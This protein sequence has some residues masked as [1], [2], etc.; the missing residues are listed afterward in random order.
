MYCMQRLNSLSLYFRPH[1]DLKLICPVLNLTSH[2]F[3]FKILIHVRVYHLIRPVLNSSSFEFPLSSKGKIITGDEI[4][5]V[6]SMWSALCSHKM[7]YKCHEHRNTHSWMKD[8]CRLQYLHIYAILYTIFVEYMCLFLYSLW[9]SYV[10]MPDNVFSFEF[11]QCYASP[12][13]DPRLK[14]PSP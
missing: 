9:S 7:H 6:C 8:M 14:S 10:Q 2:Q 4:F 3:C 1:R 12:F 13:R 5:P 11:A